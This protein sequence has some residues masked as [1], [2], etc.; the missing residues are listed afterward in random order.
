MRVL[1]TGTS[2]FTGFWFCSELASA[3]HQVHGLFQS[4]ADRYQGQRGPCKHILATRMKVEGIDNV[5][6]GSES[7]TDSNS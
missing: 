7:Q 3:G 2:S 6:I 5:T 4:P 1:F